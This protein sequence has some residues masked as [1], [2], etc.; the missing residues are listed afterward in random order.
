MEEEFNYISED[1][2]MAEAIQNIFN[3]KIRKT[4]HKTVSLMVTN[5]LEQ[6][7]GVITMFDILYHV[8]PDFLNFGIEGRELSWY[9]KLNQ[10][11]QELK[12]K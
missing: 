12:D 8:R 1:A 2:S 11:T 5:H 3:G 4:G 10:L 9:G 7:V 6:L